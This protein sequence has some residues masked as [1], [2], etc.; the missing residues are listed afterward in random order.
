[1]TFVCMAWAKLCGI[2]A[3]NYVHFMLR[4]L[5][6][7]LIHNGLICCT[8][9][10]T[11]VIEACLLALNCFLVEGH[12]CIW[13]K[14]WGKFVNEVDKIM[15]S[16]YKTNI[17]T[18]AIYVTVQFVS[19]LHVLAITLPSSGSTTPISYVILFSNLMYNFFIKS[20][21]FLYMFRAIL[22]SSSGGLNCIYTASGSSLNCAPNGHLRRVTK[23]GTTCCIDTIKSSWRW[24]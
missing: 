6:E 7:L 11:T 13:H 20:I 18:R 5:E 19:V 1:M 21:V 17:H 8:A 9:V 12:P 16:I 4:M 2:D 24:A 23:S 15:C 22:C 10:Y 14:R 3:V